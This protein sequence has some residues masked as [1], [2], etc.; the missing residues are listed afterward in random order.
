MLVVFAVVPPFGGIAPMRINA[1]G[2]IIPNTINNNF[3]WVAGAH[4]AGLRLQLTGVRGTTLMLH[5]AQIR[6]RSVLRYHSE[7]YSQAGAMP[8]F[9]RRQVHQLFL[10]IL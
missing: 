1:D 2:R 4:N 5:A 3:L 7:F 9:F 6:R 8:T 10:R